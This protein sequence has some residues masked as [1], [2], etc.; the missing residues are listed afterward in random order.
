MQA[1]IA[2]REAAISQVDLR[3]AR[4]MPDLSLSVLACTI[5]LGLFVALSSMRQKVGA[6]RIAITRRRVGTASA[7]S[8]LA[9]VYVTVLAATA[10]DFR[11]ATAFFVLAVGGLL[12][13]F[14]ARLV[15]TLATLVTAA[16]V[17][18]LGIHFLFTHVFEL[19]LP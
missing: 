10:V 5:G 7:C 11:D 19:T 17:M 8:V 13:R 4:R 16:L 1:E 3:P 12:T 15:P 18:S 9:I 2:A 6:S 14:D